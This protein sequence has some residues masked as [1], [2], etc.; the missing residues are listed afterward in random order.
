MLAH[1]N[2]CAFHGRHAF[3][4]W[5]QG[6]PGDE[7]SFSNKSVAELD[8]ALR[9]SRTRTSFVTGIALPASHT[10]AQPQKWPGPIDLANQLIAQDSRE[11]VRMLRYCGT[12]TGTLDFARAQ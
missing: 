2:T 5:D 11:H 6:V 12:A 8:Q 4:H 7:N 3:R 9:M 1:R 10:L